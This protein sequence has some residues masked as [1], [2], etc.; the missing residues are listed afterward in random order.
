MRERRESG[1]ERE[2]RAEE[3]ERERGIGG[4][5]GSERLEDGW[6]VGCLGRVK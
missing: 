1:R 4:I 6:L 3:R 5:G 2:E